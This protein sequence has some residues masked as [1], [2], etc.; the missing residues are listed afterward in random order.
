MGGGPKVQVVSALT[1][2]KP[3]MLTRALMVMEPRS[4]LKSKETRKEAS[5]KSKSISKRPKSI[6]KDMPMAP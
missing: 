2:K 1:V 5:S 6:E 3:R 4:M